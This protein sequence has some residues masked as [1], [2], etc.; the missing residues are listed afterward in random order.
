MQWLSD[1]GQVDTRAPPPVAPAREGPLIRPGYSTAIEAKGTVRREAIRM[2]LGQLLD[3]RRFLDKSRR[4]VLLP[5]PPRQDLCEL[6]AAYLIS[7]I[8]PNSLDFLE[9]ASI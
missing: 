9:C 3:Y 6:L 8:V 1:R 7:I 2:A 5:G 4:V